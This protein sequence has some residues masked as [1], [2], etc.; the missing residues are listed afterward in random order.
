MWYHEGTTSIF[1][2]FPCGRVAIYIAQSMLAQANLGTTAAVTLPAAAAVDTASR[3]F[4]CVNVAS[5][6]TWMPY[7][8]EAPID[9]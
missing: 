7:F 3:C 1:F 8:D 9:G 4:V 6:R 5:E 2:A